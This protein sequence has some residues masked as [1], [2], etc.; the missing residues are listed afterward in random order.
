MDTVIDI[1]LAGRS[2]QTLDAL[3]LF[4]SPG[5]V[6]HDF[7]GWVLVVLTVPD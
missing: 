3:D 7:T 4:Q 5:I 2:G 1:E 6:D